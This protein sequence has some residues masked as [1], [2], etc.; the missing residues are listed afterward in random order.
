[1]Y[2]II[3][4]T[5]HAI[6]GRQALAKRRSK[7]HLIP[8]PIK[9]YVKVLGILQASVGNRRLK[10]LSIFVQEDMKELSTHTLEIA[11]AHSMLDQS[12]VGTA[13]EIQSMAQAQVRVA[14]AKISRVSGLNFI[15]VEVLH[16]IRECPHQ[17]G[18]AISKLGTDPLELQMMPSCK[19]L[20]I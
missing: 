12:P 3:D 17:E 4:M 7:E 9:M 20:S 14:A 18:K 1:M 2:K 10:I 19:L 8:L 6:E 13:T 11:N 5:L 16:L 15:H